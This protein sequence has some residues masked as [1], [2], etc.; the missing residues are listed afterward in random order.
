MKLADCNS[1]W[2][3]DTSSFQL[4]MLIQLKSTRGYPLR[5]DIKQCT[6]F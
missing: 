5:R 1:A 4:L 3:G 2:L 6:A